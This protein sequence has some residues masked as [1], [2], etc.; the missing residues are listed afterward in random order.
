MGNTREKYV[1]CRGFLFR[2][3]VFMIL[4]GMTIVEMINKYCS[5]REWVSARSLIENNLDLF[6]E[7]QFS[8]YLSKDSRHLIEDMLQ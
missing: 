1:F 5:E 2:K 4:L 8:G 7:G 3:D 6:R